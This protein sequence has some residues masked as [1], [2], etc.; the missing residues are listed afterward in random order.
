[1][2]AL[3]AWQILIAQ[4]APKKNLSERQLIEF[5]ETLRRPPR[6]FGL[7]TNI[8]EDKTFSSIIKQQYNIDLGVRQSQRLIRRLGI[9]L[10]KQRPV[11]A[12]P[13]PDQQKM[14]K[15]YREDCAN[16]FSL[17]FLPPS[18]PELNPIEKSGN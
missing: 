9:R 16:R 5:N 8:W 3:L 7:N 2:K 14:H 18:S 10:R 12:K 1:M 13:D 15:K 6:N 11:I 4:V 17:N